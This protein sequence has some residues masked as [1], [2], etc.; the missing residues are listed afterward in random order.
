MSGINDKSRHVYKNWITN[1]L[2]L[3]S[4]NAAFSFVTRKNRPSSRIVQSNST[5]TV[6]VECLN[7]LR[8]RLTDATH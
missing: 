4:L 1:S 6:N 7:V 5:D 2:L 8:R 3:F